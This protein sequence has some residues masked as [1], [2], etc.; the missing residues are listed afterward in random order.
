MCAITSIFI[1]IK[2]GLYFTTKKKKKNFIVKGLRWVAF[3]TL[4]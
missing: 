3:V 2:F 1:T 4:E